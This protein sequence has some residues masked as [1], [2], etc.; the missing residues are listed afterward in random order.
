[1]FDLIKYGNNPCLE[2]NEQ[3]YTYSAVH[4]ASA[5]MGLVFAGRNLILCLCENTLPSLLGYVA[6]LV[7]GQVP[8]LIE[9]GQKTASLLDII[10]RYGPTFIWISE[11]RRDEVPNG[12]TVFQHGD[13]V[14]LRLPVAPEHDLPIDPRLQVLLTTSGSTGSS[15]FVRLSRQNLLANSNSII[16]Y[17]GI[18]PDDV[19]ITTLP[20]SYS[21]G[22]SIINTH[23]L[24]GASIQVTALNPLNRDFWELVKHKRVKSLSGVPYTFDMLKRIKFERFDLDAIRYLSQAGGKLSQD[25]L[26]YLLRVSKE[27]GFPFFVMYG[28]TEATARMSY[29]PPE[30]LERKLDSIGVAIPKGRFA[31]VDEREVVIDAPFVKGQLVYTGP[32]V[33]MGYATSR[34]D[35]ALGDEWHGQL[36]TGDVAYR[37][38]EGFYY[39]SGRLKRIVKIFGNRV[40]LDEVESLLRSSFTG[41]EFI[42]SGED[43]RL[44]ISCV[45]KIGL[46][47]VTGFA[48][49]QLGLHRTA[50]KCVAL[51][52]IPRLSNGKVNY[53]ALNQLGA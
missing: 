10:A 29:L 53:D 7:H 45:G 12:E 52:E 1:M 18:K 35:L 21:F 37:D 23:L 50:I 46:E 43:D 6:F 20:F 44:R 2:D 26:E 27:R 28:Q 8:I 22:L 13:Y 3:A 14:L 48:S 51:G 30:C 36:L 24:A 4:H 15:K 38:E 39:V 33:A 5:P 19:A 17:L 40:S 25:S 16:E 11:N 9:A 42:C 41:C 32:N 47:E 49:K 34:A 31:L